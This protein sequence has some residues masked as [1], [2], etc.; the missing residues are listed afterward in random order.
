MSTAIPVT[1]SQFRQNFQAFKNANCFPNQ[2]VAFWLSVAEKLINNARWGDLTDVGV[3]L[4]TAHQIALERQALDAA[5]AGGVPGQ[6]TGL[7]NSKSVDK[8]SVG[9]DTQGGAELDAG[10]WNLTT[11]GSRYIRLARMMGTGGLQIGVGCLPG[12]SSLSSY[13]AWAGVWTPNFPNMNQ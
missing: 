1:V 12:D 11:Y 13:N 8:V 7:I 3:Q 9:F 4:F 10:H 6:A 5:N 2:V